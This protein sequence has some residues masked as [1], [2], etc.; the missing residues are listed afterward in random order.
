MRNV[1]AVVMAST[2]A[3]ISLA[4]QAADFPTGVNWPQSDNLAKR[5]NAQHHMFDGIKL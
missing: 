5:N 3:F 4:S 2:L 1:T